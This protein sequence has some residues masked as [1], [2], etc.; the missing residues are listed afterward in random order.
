[1]HFLILLLACAYAQEF[2]LLLKG[3]H[4]IDGR[5]GL[6][7]VRDVGIKDGKIAAVA[8][9]IDAARALKTVDVTGLYVTPGLIDIHVHVYAGTGER[10]SYAGDNSVYP[11]GFTYRNG[12]TTVA[13]A[14]SS[15]WRNFEDFKDRVIDRSRTRVLAFLNIVGH[16]MRGGRYEQNMDD[17]DGKATAEM[18]LKHKGLIVGVKTAH[19]DGPQ[20]KAVDQ[21]L[22]AGR[23]AKI[24]VMVDF[25]RAYPER[26]LAELLNDKFRPGDIFTHCYGG[27]RGELINGRVN[28][29]ILPAQKR[30]IIF[31]VGHGGGSFVYQT[32]VQAFKEGYYPNSISTDLHIGSM[33]AGMKDMLNVMSKIM[34]LGMSLDDVIVRSTW[35]PAREIQHEELGHLSPGA[36]ADVAV[37]RL[38][39]GKFGFVDQN[40]G[41]MDG[42]QKLICELTLRDGRVVYDLNGI[43]RERW[44]K[45][46]PGARGGDPRWDGFASPRRAGTKK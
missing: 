22:A 41:R 3:G 10:G 13:D 46:S 30:G 5:N 31:D 4:V 33:N 45:M 36:I 17:M 39:K 25:G 18:A 16:G 1:M 23:T 20:W 8:Q 26:S 24:P 11:D 27:A 29:A 14:G 43:T 19:F 15:G 6:S 9:R 7:A 44:D 34:A 28:P 21:A 42:T 12:V 35:N 40:G 38:E 37:L 32:A 2:D